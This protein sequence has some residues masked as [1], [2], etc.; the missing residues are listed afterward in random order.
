MLSLKR[1]AAATAIFSLCAASQAAPVSGSGTWETT[2]K[3]RDINGAAVAL[4]SASA[5]F[6]YDTVLD[7]TWMANMNQDGKKAWDAAAAWAEQLT[8]GGF[9]DWRLPGVR[10]INGTEF[11]MTRTNNGSTDHGYAKTGVGWGK[12]SEWGHLFY[13]TL[14]NIGRC[15]PND[16]NPVSCSV[17]DGHGAVNTAYFEDIGPTY[18][19]NLDVPDPAGAW[20]F[21]PADGAQQIIQDGFQLTVV[22][23]RDGDVLGGAPTAVP[24]PQSLALALAA[25]AGLGLASRKVRKVREG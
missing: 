24:E 10:P 18:W 8:L 2:L 11:Q 9:T 23:V 17:Q 4:N 20:S 25:L 7:I 22:A 13:V 19:A 5:A 1:F 12:A 3:A 6:F 14:G 16:S 21:A 15:T